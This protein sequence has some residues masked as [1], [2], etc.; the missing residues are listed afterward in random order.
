MLAKLAAGRSHD[1][2]FVEEALQAKLVDPNQLRLGLELIP[3]SHRDLT[4][5]RLARILDQLEA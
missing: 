5:E 2:E 1:L 3:D 4:R